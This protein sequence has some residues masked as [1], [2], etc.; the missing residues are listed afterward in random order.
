MDKPLEMAVDIAVDNFVDWFDQRVGTNALALG[1]W[2]PREQRS[3]LF[4]E[5]HLTCFT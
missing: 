1:Q 3:H 4:D 2:T 5:G